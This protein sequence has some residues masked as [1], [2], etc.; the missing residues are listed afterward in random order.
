MMS[1]IRRRLAGDERG[2][3]LPELIVSMMLLAM[4]GA[5]VLS[6]FSM[7]ARTFTRDRSQTDSTNIAAI[8]MS[9]LTRVIRSGTEI[10]V[11]GS[12]LNTP[13]FLDARNDS[14]VMHAFLDTESA[15]PK[16]LK[17]EFSIDGNRQLI[18]SRW[19]A[20]AASVPYWT[21]GAVGRPA[22][23]SRPIARQ[24]PVFD[25]SVDPQHLFRYRSATVCPVATPDCN[26]LTP[27]LG[28][29][30]PES[31]RRLIAIV[32]IR[33]KVQADLTVRAEPV[34]LVNQVGLPNLGIDRV[35]ASQ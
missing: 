8:G 7:F 17:V 12:S 33:L 27:P 28:G 34:T 3:G 20:E 14:V 23:T 25:A 30:L 4:L 29:S 18:E 22:D 11:S 2:L 16:P 1:A 15:S 32:E 26:V 10:R 21:F 35:G 31:E 6:L 13:V 24:I 9:E 5:L 19:F